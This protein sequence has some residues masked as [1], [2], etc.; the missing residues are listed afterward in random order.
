MARVLLAA[1]N[2][3]SP[4]LRPKLGEPMRIMILLVAIAVSVMGSVA[5]VLWNL[6]LRDIAE[7]RREL[8][9]LDLLLVGETEQAMQSVDLVLKNVRQHVLAAGVGSVDRLVTVFGGR[10]THELL[11]SKIVGMPQVDALAIVAADGQVLNLSRV[12]PVPPVDIAD[13]EYFAALRASPVDVAVLSRPVVSRLTGKEAMFLG[14]RLTAPSG[15]FIGVVLAT[16]DLGYFDRHY[17]AL[18]AGDRATVSL[19]HKDGI[20]VTR[21][22]LSPEPRSDERPS[23]GAATGTGDPVAYESAR[24]AQAPARVVVAAAARDFPLVVAISKTFDQ[25]LADWRRKAAFVAGGAVLL[26]A[27]L[28]VGIWLLS[29]QLA[30]YEALKVAIAERGMAVAAREEAE[31]QLRQAQKLEAIGQLTGGIAHDFNNLLTAVLGNLELLQ[32]HSNADD[33]KIQRWIRNAIEAA[34]RG[35]ALTTRLLA[36]SRRQP[37]E[38]RPVD[39]ASLLDSLSD[40]L[41]RTLGEGIEVT[42]LIEP[43]LW[44]IFVDPSGL[45]NAILNIAL[46]ARDAMDGRGRLSIE[47]TNHSAEDPAHGCPAAASGDSVRIAISDSGRGIAKDVLER[48]FEP[49]FTTKPVGQGT[50]LGLSQ[51]YGFVTQS[52]GRIRLASEVGQGTIV[53]I[54]L[55]RA[56]TE[57]PEGAARSSLCEDDDVADGTS[58]GKVLV[59]E[60]DDNVRSY[61]AETFRDLGFATAEAAEARAALA[62]LAADRAIT[63]LFT[64]VGLPGMNGHEL[65]AAARELRPDL[66]VLLTTGYAQH[67]FVDS[68]DPAYP[69]NLI[70]KPFT[71]AELQLKLRTFATRRAPVGQAI[72]VRA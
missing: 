28:V 63:L 46:N 8:S 10:D 72:A 61:A 65:A 29:R 47:A 58:R 62:L 13:R 4:R 2:V 59:V 48:V 51:V 37:L 43:G 49:F 50:G 57:E 54:F 12:F 39:V 20:L 14:R 41:I 22:P 70:A 3:E 60:N 40:L 42:T 67:G 52:G 18:R 44:T 9:T 36:F 66:D 16:I 27:G 55:P 11:G 71:R 15:D 30:T 56:L 23:F 45:D 5:L 21:F 19:W 7:A 69:A 53:E 25:I 24:T 26:M 32:R 68:D 38:P 31:A 64:D 6:R 34:R 1:A 35:A 17:E 33:P